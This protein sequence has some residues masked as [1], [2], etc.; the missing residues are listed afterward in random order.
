LSDKEIDTL[1]AENR[2][3]EAKVQVKSFLG[4]C[5]VVL[6]VLLSLRPPVF[7][8]Q[9]HVLAITIQAKSSTQPLSF[10][11]YDTLFPVDIS[12][13][14][15]N[16]ST[17]DFPGGNVTG[18]ITPPSGGRYYFPI[19][20]SVPKLSPGESALYEYDGFKAPES[21]V[22]TVHFDTISTL[23]FYNPVWTV[24]GGLSVIDVEPPSTLIELWSVMTA[25]LVGFSSLALSIMYPAIR[26]RRRKHQ[27]DEK[28]ERA[29]YRLLK[30]IIDPIWARE[31]PVKQTVN[32][33]P[34]ELENINRIIADYGDVL[35]DTTA[36]LWYTKMITQILDNGSYRTKLNEFAEDVRT[37]YKRVI[38]KKRE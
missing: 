32:M 25:V 36:N 27:L 33:S 26:D 1:L 2:A 3:S 29:A 8:H 9:Q 18:G 17:D 4:V 31:A 23:I 6:V 14:I 38:Q 13:L 22:Y 12:I 5:I 24:S 21:G 35:K 16:L 11:I 34:S 7:G 20:Y 28:R 37:N 10:G 19:Q 30:G 15:R